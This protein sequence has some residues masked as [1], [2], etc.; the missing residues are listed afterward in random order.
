M[1]VESLYKRYEKELEYA[2]VTFCRQGELAKDG[3]QQ[4]F[5]Q[6]LL[7]RQMLESMPEQAAKAWLFATARNFIIDEMR[8]GKRLVLTGEDQWFE[9]ETKD[10][11]IQVEMEALI[12]ALPSPQKE[13]VVLRYYSQL[14]S[15]QIG[16]MLQMDPST[17]R[18]HLNQSMKKLKKQLL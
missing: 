15:G 11:F 10:E 5:L 9:G 18:Y 4:A 17:V 2:M 3:R 12:E 8:K 7:R 13:I 16:Q 1:T 6:A 14:H